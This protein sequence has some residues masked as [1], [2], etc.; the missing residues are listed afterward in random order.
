MGVVSRLGLRQRVS[1]T[2]GLGAFLVAVFVAVTTYTIAAN[3]LWAQ[4]ESTTLRQ[5]SFNARAVNAALAA[6]Q[7]PSMDELLDR[8]DSVGQ[9]SSPIIRWHDHWYADRFRPGIDALPHTFLAAAAAGE[10]AHERIQLPTGDVVAVAV[11]LDEGSYVEVFPLDE[12]DRTLATLAITFAVTT[13]L[14]TAL[15]VLVGRWASRRALRP[16]ATVTAA[17]GA[18]AAG[19]L[20]ARI[21]EQR[22][23]D[24]NALAEAFDD[25]ATKL[26][27]RVERDA[28]FAAD[29]SHELRS[30][31]T[32]MVN[33]V[34]LLL[35][36]LQELEP[37]TQE[38][39]L[40]LSDDVHRF[41]EMVKDLLE[42]ALLDTA[43]LPLAEQEVAVTVLVASV[44]DRLAGREVTRASPGEDPVVT[45]DPRRLE[46]IVE[47]L[48]RNAETHGNGVIGVWVEHQ[49]DTVRLVVEDHGP[50]IPE[51]ARERIFER[52][53][54]GS[55]LSASS[56]VGLGL[57]LVSE[58]V[59]RNN[60]RVWVE[61]GAQGGARFVVELPVSQ[62][63]A[64]GWPS[65][66]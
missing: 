33:A 45:V 62:A 66:G 25:T 41:A 48:V 15:G 64:H 52:F 35:D 42:L 40:L 5:A 65:S 60:G 32:T 9:T 13:T 36:R 34:D 27:A 55:A 2:F 51:D 4:R 6:E 21:G 49:G 1:V 56:G 20:G 44:A 31:L 58:H 50:G 3:Y 19:D 28:R 17:A 8:V 37:E 7:R 24:L 11:P 54:R 39:L 16:L 14:A 43:P 18:I 57:S 59:R 22:D 53:A 46:R 10:S 23:P 61:N 47:N 12:L 63:A 26:K 38:I 30:P 29:V